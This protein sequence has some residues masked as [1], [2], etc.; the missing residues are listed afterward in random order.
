MLDWLWF[1][2][3]TALAAVLVAVPVVLACVLSPWF[4]LLLGATFPLAQLCWRIGR[5]YFEESK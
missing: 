4:L 1:F 2:L 5:Y 3:F